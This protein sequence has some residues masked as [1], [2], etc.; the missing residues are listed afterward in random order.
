M[1]LF[2]ATL[3]LLALVSGVVPRNSKSGLYYCE[4]TLLN[5]ECGERS[6]KQGM[7]VVGGG[8]GTRRGRGRG[9]EGD[10]EGMEGQGEGVRR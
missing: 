1:K 5:I 8:E 9:G 7:V 4:Q 3:S 6:G 10:E 2:S